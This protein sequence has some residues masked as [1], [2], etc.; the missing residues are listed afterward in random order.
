MTAVSADSSL[1]ASL[2]SLIAECWAPGFRLA[3]RLT[4]CPAAAEDVVQEALV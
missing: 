3:L 4:D 1:D 2:E